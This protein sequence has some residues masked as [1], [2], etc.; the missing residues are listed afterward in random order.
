MGLIEYFTIVTAVGGL[1]LGVINIILA[2]RK[3]SVRI[4][5]FPVTLSILKRTNQK[6]FFGI[7]VI[8]LS[9]FPVTISQIK[10]I[11]RNKKGFLHFVYNTMDGYP[12]PY[13]M[14]SKESKTFV[15]ASFKISEKVKCI[16]VITSCKTK[17]KIAGK[18]IKNLHT[19][20]YS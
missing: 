12:L 4:K 2:L 9:E 5:A 20:D 7:E 15:P 13:R 11:L 17:V 10:I 18:H 19:Y 3:G 14:N 16:Q 8:N 1:F 6:V